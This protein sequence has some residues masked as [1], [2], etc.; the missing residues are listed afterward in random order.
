LRKALVVGIDYYAT[1]PQLSGCVNDAHEV[2][3][4][5]ERHSD[6]SVNFGVKMMVGT[7]IQSAISR[8]QLK[9][10]IVELFSGSGEIAVLYFAGHGYFESTGGYILASDARR[11]DD[12]ISLAEIANLAAS[13]AIR[14]R[15]VI[16]DSCFSGGLADRPQGSSAELSEGMTVLT[17]STAEQPAVE[18]GGGG[19][20][21][22]LLVDALRGSAA[23]LLG[24]IT[25]GS[26]YAHIDQS[27]GPWDQR[28][29]FKTNVKEFVSL[30]NA[31]PSV[32]PSVL[33]RIVEF[34]PNPGT[35][36][37]L[38][39]S[40]EPRDEGRTPEMPRASERNTVR[41]SVLQKYNRAGLVVPVGA[42]HMWN[43]AMESKAC[44]LTVLG[45][46]YRRLVAT[47]RI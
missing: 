7:G 38:D 20:F 1:L 32:E 25:P 4:V 15:V 36:F 47:N 29:V 34:F 40:F 18:F 35:E 16:L 14:N 13:A 45:E 28:P 27:L 46:H 24:S 2:K 22:R 9:D 31:K 10:S 5:L 44:K 17:A 21:T 37:P 12:G 42:D 6:G 41:F 39:P 23:N 19:V 8:I 3:G 11:G 33:R 26:V 43:A 30:R